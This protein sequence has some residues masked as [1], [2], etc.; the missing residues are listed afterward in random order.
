MSIGR[1]TRHHDVLRLLAAGVA[2]IAHAG[3]LSAQVVCAGAKLQPPAVRLVVSIEACD[4]LSAI[5]EPRHPR[6][7]VPREQSVRA[8]TASRV[9]ALERLLADSLTRVFTDNFGFLRWRTTPSAE[10]W[11]LNVQLQQPRGAGTLPMVRLALNHADTLVA[12]SEPVVLEP[13]EKV[14]L[15]FD[16]Q[17]GQGAGTLSR[18][19]A[20]LTAEM[21]ALITSHDGAIRRKWVG[22]VLKRV[23]LMSGSLQPVRDGQFAFAQL[24]IRDGDIRAEPDS[25]PRFEWRINQIRTQVSGATAEDPGAF[26]VGECQSVTGGY[27]CKLLDLLYGS[28]RFSTAEA[29]AAFVRD[30]TPTLV[31]PMSLYVTDYRPARRACATVGS[32]PQ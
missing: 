30:K 6:E 14:D 19:N 3:A 8:D 20:R 28:A 15:L 1:P 17:Q 9:H 18:T 22:A 27:H 21:I 11:T 32:M 25:R 29:T 4:Y 5:A 13:Y 16:E 24:P 12:A 2:L 10:R 7:C 26:S 23:P 31:P